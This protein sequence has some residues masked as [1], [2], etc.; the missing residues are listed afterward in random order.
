SCMMTLTRGVRAHYPCPVCLVP[1]L[2]LSDL[3][4]NYPLRTTESMKE[5]YERACLLSAEKAEDLLKLHGLRKVPNVFWEIERSDPYHAVSWDRLHAFLIGLFD[6][7]LGR[8]IEHIDRL[9]GRQARQAKIIVD[10]V[11]VRNRCFDYS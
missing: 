5:I 8:L 4:T 11:Y 9:P 1:L 7:L 2:N 10:E 3:S 6:H